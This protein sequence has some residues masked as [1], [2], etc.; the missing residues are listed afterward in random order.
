MQPTTFLD[1]L[2]TGQYLPAIGIALIAIVATARKLLGSVWPWFLT[3]AGGY[4]LGYGSAA[5]LYLGA[6]LEAGQ[7]PTLS[8]A[9]GALGA[10]W[11]AAGGWEGFRD[12]FLAVKKTPPPSAGAVSLVLVVAV[13]LGCSSGCKDGPGSGPG[14]IAT[15]IDCAKEDQAQLSALALELAPLAMGSSPDWKAIEARAIGAGGRIGG[16]VLAELVQAFLGGRRAIPNDASWTAHETLERFRATQ[17]GGATFRTKV[18][19]L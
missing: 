10:G 4:V 12:F 3:K 13:G 17:A 18:G 8:L 5:L 19:D 1:Y 7:V 15:I 14:P 2:L 11:V 6:A 9:M 16:C